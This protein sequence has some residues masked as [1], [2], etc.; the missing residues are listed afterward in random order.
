[1]DR[2]PLPPPFPVGTKLRYLGAN[3]SWSDLEQKEPIQWPGMVVEI[4]RVKQGRQGDLHVIEIDDYGEEVLD[5]TRDG[6]SVWGVENGFIIWPD[7]AH[8]WEVVA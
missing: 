5:E 1:M 2:T 3:R 7:R 4:I 8:E 6:Y